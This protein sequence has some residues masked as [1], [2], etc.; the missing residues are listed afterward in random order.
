MSAHLRDF[1]IERRR[2]ARL[3]LALFIGALA[4]F[5]AK[6]GT[7]LADDMLAAWGSGLGEEER[8]RRA[9]RLFRHR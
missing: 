6:L 4:A 7:V 3:C 2:F 1:H 5:I 8:R 9:R